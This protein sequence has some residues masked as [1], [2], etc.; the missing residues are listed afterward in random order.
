VAAFF[1]HKYLTNP[2][3]TPEDQVILAAARPTDTLQGIKSPQ[4]HT[5]T[6]QALGDLRDIFYEAAS[7]TNASLFPAD[8]PSRKEAP[9]PPR[10]SPPD[11]KI[12]KGIMA[13]SQHPHTD[14]RVHPNLIPNSPNVDIRVLLHARRIAPPIPTPP[15]SEV[16]VCNPIVACAFY[17]TPS[18]KMRKK[19]LG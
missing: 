14:P 15:S 7:T 11:P 2:S 4:L 1:K 6:L 12:R 9:L 3:A 18:H 16:G 13:P 10:D 17:N 5:S 19:L 8:T